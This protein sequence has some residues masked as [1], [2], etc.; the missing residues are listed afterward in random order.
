[1][2]TYRLYPSKSNTL[3]QNTPTINTGLNEVMELWY[4]EDGV[5][6]HLIRFEFSGYNQQYQL[7]YVPHITGTTATLKLYP[8]YP[9]RLETDEVFAN[10]F[11]L[12]VG[13]VQQDWDEGE[14]YNFI[15]GTAGFSNWTSAAT[16]TEWASAGGDYLYQVFSG[17]YNA[18]NEVLSLDVTDEIELWS[19]FTG[20][21][22]GLIVKYTDD[23][24]ALTGE[25]KTIAKF[26]TEKTHTYFKPYIELIW[27]DSYSASSGITMSGYDV[28]YK[29]T[30][31]NLLESY[32]NY[33]IA[34]I[35][36]KIYQKY[37][38]TE[39]TIDN[40]EFRISLI[41]GNNKFTFKDWDTVP[42]SDSYGNRLTIMF[43][44]FYYKHKYQIEFRYKID[45][46]VYYT[47]NDR[48]EFKV[49]EA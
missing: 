19:N 46:A 25:N 30:I 23:Y 18:A 28:D 13:V 1:M 37:T 10:S 26:F 7:G 5:T 11:D 9:I 29:I 32:P 43:D 33:G 8:C 31:P 35:P 17:H 22:F 42:Y 21:N 36:L 2:G 27:T 49:V 20:N 12:E 24:E 6:R 41:D 34:N 40:L 3:I 15:G 16:L 4:G 45:D 38:S 44:Y 48:F 14:G 39:V 47:S